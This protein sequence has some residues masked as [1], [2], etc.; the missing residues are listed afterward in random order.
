VRNRLAHV[1]LHVFAVIVS[2]TTASSLA[3]QL[4]RLKA[5]I[6]GNSHWHYKLA[7]DMNASFIKQARDM[8]KA[9]HVITSI[10]RAIWLTFVLN[11]HTG[12]DEQQRSLE[13]STEQRSRGVHAGGY[14]HTAVRGVESKKTL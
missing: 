8:H 5:G 4:G 11:E 7:E 6:L 3:Y 9:G 14:K 2:A 10:P 13:E 12:V 1:N